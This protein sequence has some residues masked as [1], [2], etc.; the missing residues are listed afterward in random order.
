M[1]GSMFKHS[2]SVIAT[3]CCYIVLKLIQF[4]GIFLPSWG[5]WSIRILF[6]LTAFNELKRHHLFADLPLEQVNTRLLKIKQE[7][8]LT[9]VSE[10]T[11]WNIF[12]LDVNKLKDKGIN[13]DNLMCNGGCLTDS[14]LAVMCKF[15]VD[16]APPSLNYGKPAMYAD[17]LRMLK[18]ADIAKPATA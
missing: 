9:E 3:L 13:V 15:I 17:V 16:S 1:N 4:T 18:G 8:V 10:V 5:A 14:E 7:A 2:S 11:Q 12:H 6:I